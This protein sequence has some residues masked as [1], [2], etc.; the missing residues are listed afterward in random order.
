MNAEMLRSLKARRLFLA[1]LGAGAGGRP[2][3][4]KSARPPTVAGAPVIELQDGREFWEVWADDRTEPDA[5]PAR[6]AA[7]TV[8]P[9]RRISGRPLMA[10]SRR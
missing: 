7:V 4:E 5:A 10:S 1:L 2:R 6:A 9:A 8:T 3:T